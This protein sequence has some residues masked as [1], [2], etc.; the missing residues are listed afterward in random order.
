MQ[1]NSGF[2][3]GLRKLLIDVARVVCCGMMQVRHEHCLSLLSISQALTIV[4]SG[5]EMAAGGLTIGSIVGFAAPRNEERWTCKMNGGIRTSSTCAVHHR[6]RC[7]SFYRRNSPKACTA[8]A[9]DGDI[10]DETTATPVRA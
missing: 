3:R 2:I 9:I 5:V 1:L 8:D 7:V 10:V 6:H 4:N